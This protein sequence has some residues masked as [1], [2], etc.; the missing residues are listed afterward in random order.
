[1][2][3]IFQNTFFFF[4]SKDKTPEQEYLCWKEVS[5]MNSFAH[6]RIE[7]PEIALF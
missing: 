5:Q 1:M 2:K 7:L 6:T 3:L 4:L